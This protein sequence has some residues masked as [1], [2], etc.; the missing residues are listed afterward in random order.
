MI[1]RL[2]SL[3]GPQHLYSIY[4]PRLALG[5]QGESTDLEEVTSRYVLR[6]NFFLPLF[7]RR[8]IQWLRRCNAD[9]AEP[10][11]L[12][13][14]VRSAS[15]NIVSFEFNVP[16]ALKIGGEMEAL[17]LEYDDS[18]CRRS[19]NEESGACGFYDHRQF[20]NPSLSTMSHRIKSISLL[21]GW[22]SHSVVAMSSG[23]HDH[24]SKP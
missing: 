9:E 20:P 19:S 14:E 24:R 21:T 10:D 18:N 11:E 17:L 1:Q 23:I 12:L 22:P 7:V 5:R 8:R 3:H 13:E 16:D 2:F 4:L 6:S 15:L